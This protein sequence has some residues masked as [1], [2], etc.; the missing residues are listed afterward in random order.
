MIIS[1]VTL[2]NFGLYRGEHTVAFPNSEDGRC[3]TLIGGLNGRGKTT[4]LDAVTLAMY[5]KR[6]LRM[7]QNERIKYSTYILNHINKSAKPRKA[8]IT[9]VLDG[10]SNF[11]GGLIIERSWSSDSLDS[12]DERFTV[13]HDGA[14]DKYLSENWDYYVE[15]ILPLNISRF[16][17][18]DNEKI[19]QIADDET[20]ESVKTSI[21]V[22]LGITTIDQLIEDMS[23]LMSSTYAELK[24]S[25]R[26]DVLKKIADVEAEINTTETEIQE[27]I[28]ETGHLRTRLGSAKKQYEEYERDFWAKGGKLGLQK[29]EI[30]QKRESLENELKEQG[31]DALEAASLSGTPLLLCPR[32]VKDAY[33]LHRASEESR[34]AAYAG[35]IIDRMH[36]LLQS[37]H[38][39][40]AFVVQA[41]SFL[42][43]ARNQIEGTSHSDES[44]LSATAQAMLTQFV[45]T[46]ADR[47][48]ALTELVARA[49][50]IEN[51]IANIDLLLSFEASENDVKKLWAD[52]QKLTAETL[53][54]EMEIR[55]KEERLT[56]LNNRLEM[57]RRRREAVHKENLSTMQGRDESLRKIRY[58][59]MT[60]NVMAEFRKRILVQR[61]AELQN[62]IYEC[63]S[64]MV[65]KDSIIQG[66][67]IDPD[68]LDIKLIDYNGN[69]LLKDQLSAGEK[70]LFAVSIIWGL[71]Q[72]S[73]YDMPVI[74]DT[75][76]GRLDSQHRTNFVE[77]Y[78]PYASKQVIVLSTD[79]EVNGK[80]W[81]LI[82][83]NVNAVYTL[84]YDEAQ[85][86]SSIQSGYFGGQQV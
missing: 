30:T 10:L 44:S 22:L 16:F 57:L 18:F 4:F 52:M 71:A 76:L 23:K 54:Y 55:G 45:M 7:L 12:V 11:P 47:S 39:D 68:T 41:E 28:Q 66:I 50:K 49:R 53:Q 17:F 36:R 15:E 20:F 8:G 69:E 33:D 62:K 79:E 38:Y 13:M 73:G 70:Q 75:P 43:T 85:H 1:R 34:A 80:Y 48:I 81:D 72:S 74:I 14:E 51:E 61:S 25:A 56:Q 77:R 58:A 35:R 5:G 31:E 32:L 37:S 46:C 27:N 9:I 59:T 21:K 67:R 29:E 64:F 19:A 24:N 60:Q 6:A 3:V 83:P 63:F 86:G 2:F 40:A 26:S 82:K 78:L 42:Q 65:Q 84:V